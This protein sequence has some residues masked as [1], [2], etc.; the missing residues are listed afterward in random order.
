MDP[1]SNTLL[2]MTGGL[3]VK[4]IDLSR[5][6]PRHP[7]KRYKTRDESK[8][9][10]VVLHCTDRD[11]STQQ[12]AEY[13]VTGKLTYVRKVDGQEITDIN[14]IDETGLPG[15]TYHDTVG[16][17][18]VEHSLPYVEVSYHAA[19]YNTRSVAIGMLYRT[20]NPATGKAEYSPPE[21]MVKL[22]QCHAAELCLKFGLSPDRIFGHRELK[23]TGWD[24][25]RGRKRLLKTCPGPYV[26]M[27]E[28]RRNAA[29]YMQIQLKLA[30]CYTGAIDGLFGSRSKAALALY[31]RKNA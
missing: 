22:A 19:G 14:H 15:L 13:D 12:V 10:M 17:S 25:I 2:E 3:D 6:L 7:S 28:I 31:R 18:K 23:G 20:T 30:G 1:D 5:E 9:D 29:V 4:P 16:E 27:D 8:I 26:D 11:W 21:G 24:W